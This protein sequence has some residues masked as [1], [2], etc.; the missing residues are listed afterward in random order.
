MEKRRGEPGV[1]RGPHCVSC[2]RGSSAAGGLDPPCSKRNRQRP[3]RGC[4]TRPRRRNSRRGAQA[5]SRVENDS[6]AEAAMTCLAEAAALRY[7]G[8]GWPVLPLH[9][10]RGGSCTC[11]RGAKCD[12]PGKHPRTEHGVIDASNRRGC[13]SRLVGTMARCKRGDPHRSRIGPLRRRCRPAPRRPGE[14][15]ESSTPT[16]GAPSDHDSKD[17]RRW[18][19]SPLQ[20][21][22]F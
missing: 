17:R 8:L 14:S 1:H 18:A 12:S 4:S 5:V 9:S 19:T 10:I 22:R 2:R 3:S 20:M 11:S 7:A 16:R 13:D 15:R 21:A 6:V